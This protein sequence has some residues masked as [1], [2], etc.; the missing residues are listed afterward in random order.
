[1]R[2]LLAEASRKGKGMSRSR[3]TEQQMLGALR[4]LEAGRKV[5]EVAREAGVSKPTIYVWKA[6]YSGV[7]KN[8]IEEANRL[9]EENAQ[10]KKLVLDLSLDREMLKSALGKNGLNS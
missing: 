4:Q 6:K 10:L 2:R 7:D 3:Y 9:R 8:E 5:E 1:M